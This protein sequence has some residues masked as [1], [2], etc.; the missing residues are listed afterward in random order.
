VHKVFGCISDGTSV[1][2]KDVLS[3]KGEKKSPKLKLQVNSY[4]ILTGG[5]VK[6]PDGEDVTEEYERGTEIVP[7]L[8]QRYTSGAPGCSKL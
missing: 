5:H 4:G 7:E 8:I 3:Q 6:T 2:N 1:T